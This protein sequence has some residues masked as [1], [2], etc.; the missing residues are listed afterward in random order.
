[1]EERARRSP[2]C[3]SPDAATAPGSAPPS[4]PVTRCSAGLFSSDQ[5][6]CRRVIGSP[7]VRERLDAN[8]AAG[9]VCRENEVLGSAAQRDD[10]PAVVDIDHAGS[11][12][13]IEE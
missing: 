11:P 4:T 1:M 6:K 12:L 9:G 8:F 2:T 7:S 10:R 13:T 3:G 5:R